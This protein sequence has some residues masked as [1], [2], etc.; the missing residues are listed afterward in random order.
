MANV[1]IPISRETMTG[2]KMT[3]EASPCGICPPPPLLRCLPQYYSQKP[4]GKGGFYDASSEQVGSCD[5][6][7]G[8]THILRK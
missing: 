1:C 8:D 7:D 6:R 4:G 2:I 5:Y 3:S